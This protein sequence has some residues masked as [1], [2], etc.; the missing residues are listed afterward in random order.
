LGKDYIAGG[1]IIENVLPFLI[2]SSTSS[3]NFLSM[4]CKYRNEDSAR[5][6]NAGSEFQDFWRGDSGEMEH[7]SLKRL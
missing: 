6:T 5:I 1:G 7:G 3:H 2:V 4:L